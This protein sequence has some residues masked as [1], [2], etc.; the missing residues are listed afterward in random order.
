VL[1]N[2]AYYNYNRGVKHR[3][4]AREEEG[5]DKIRAE[6]K[7]LRRRTTSFTNEALLDLLP[8]PF[9]FLSTHTY[10]FL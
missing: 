10:H 6:K 4:K 2:S 8:A 1:R 3:D 5:G 9:Q 7:K